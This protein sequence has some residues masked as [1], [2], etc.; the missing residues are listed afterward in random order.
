MDKQ[1]VNQNQRAE[2]KVLSLAMGAKLL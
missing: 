2:E 1:A